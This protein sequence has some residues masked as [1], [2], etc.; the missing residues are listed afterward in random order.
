MRRRRSS[1]H[2]CRSRLATTA[3]TLSFLAADAAPHKITMDPQLIAFAAG[4]LAL[5][6]AILVLRPSTSLPP[7]VPHRTPLTMVC[8]TV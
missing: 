7:S 5:V 6:V 1:F 2:G 3:E 4:F 8:T